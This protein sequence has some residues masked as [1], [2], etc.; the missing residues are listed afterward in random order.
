MSAGNS[1][2]E[3]ARA[4]YRR[5]RYYVD[6]S[7]QRPLLVAVVALEVALVA[8]S[9]WLVHW[10]LGH[11]IDA[12]MYR[13]HAARE[14][15]TLMRLALEAF[16]V[17]ALF[18]VVNLTALTLAAWR[19]SLHENLALQRFCALIA[20]TRGLDFSGDPE[21]RGQHV[22]LALATAWRKR[23]RKRFAAIRAQVAQLE[24]A[25]SAGASVQELRDAVKRLNQILP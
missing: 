2:G 5:R 10:R 3:I 9:I 19:W 12:S 15:I 25:A 18:V 7:I 21:E 11:A 6:G 20:K 22:A 14:R 23:E 8:A 24:A 17:L 4:A 13:M 1:A 16:P